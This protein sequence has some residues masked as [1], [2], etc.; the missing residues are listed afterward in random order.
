MTGRPTRGSQ[1]FHLPRR[2]VRGHLGRRL[3]PAAHHRRPVR[4][5][6]FESRPARRD[7]I[8][9]SSGALFVRHYWGHPRWFLFLRLLICLNSAGDPARFEVEMKAR[10][11][12]ARDRPGRRSPN[13]VPV[14]S[15]LREEA[16]RRARPNPVPGIPPRPE[17]SRAD[18][19]SPFGRTDP[20]GPKPTGVSRR[21]VFTFDARTNPSPAE[22]GDTIC[23]QKFKVS[24]RTQ[25]DRIIAL[26]YVLPR[27]TSLG[28]RR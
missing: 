23:V 7:P 9:S 12:T 8:S 22:A 21:K 24:R 10:G 27:A 14:E 18:T 17:P 25:F 16:F 4:K 19:S 11:P 1:G 3:P 28:I 20:E 26:C 2:T 5:L 13:G 6:Q 15:D